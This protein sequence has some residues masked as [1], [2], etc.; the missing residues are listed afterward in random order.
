[1]WHIEEFEGVW[2]EGYES[3]FFGPF[4]WTQLMRAIKWA[5]DTGSTISSWRR[6]CTWD[7]HPKRGLMILLS[8][9][10][11]FCPTH[12]FYLKNTANFKWPIS[13][14]VATNCSLEEPAMTRKEQPIRLIHFISPIILKSSQ[15]FIQ[16]KGKPK[17][18]SLNFLFMKFHTWCSKCVFFIFVIVISISFLL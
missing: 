18:T 8:M 11:V 13:P 7:F 15:Y 6:S 3:V 5:R 14:A 17:Q 4:A 10:Q 16:T 1:M 12:F 9:T 2:F